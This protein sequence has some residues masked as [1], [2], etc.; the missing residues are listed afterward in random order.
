AFPRTGLAGGARGHGDISPAAHGG[1]GVAARPVPRPCLVAPE[2][3]GS[4]ARLIPHAPEASVRSTPAPTPRLVRL[5]PQLGPGSGRGFLVNAPRGRRAPRRR[6]A[7]PASLDR[8]R[9]QD[10]SATGRD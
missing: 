9:A 6:L 2:P 5:R 7:G 3:P 10:R 8:R 1:A 4:A